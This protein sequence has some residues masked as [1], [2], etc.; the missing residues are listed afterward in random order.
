MNSSD[1]QNFKPKS[2]WEKPEGT[3]GM[4]VGVVTAGAALMGLYQILPWLITLTKNMLTLGLELMA[5]AGL[6]YVVA[7]SRFRNLLSFGYKSAI[8]FMTGIF[9]QIDPSTG[10]WTRS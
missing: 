2:F 10:T 5:L 6:I 1:F 4:A 7:D 9:I 3:A 8:R